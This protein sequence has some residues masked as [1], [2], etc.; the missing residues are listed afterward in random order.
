MLCESFSAY[1]N[2]HISLLV[3]IS[4]YLY[5]AKLCQNKVY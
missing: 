4:L 2:T 1:D 3:F 5:F